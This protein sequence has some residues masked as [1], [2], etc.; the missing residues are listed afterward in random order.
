[1]Q[2]SSNADSVD[3]PCHVIR[4]R[5]RQDLKEIHDPSIN[6]ITLSVENNPEVV[7]FL[8]QIA[9]DYEEIFFPISVPYGCSVFGDLRN[10]SEYRDFLEEARVLRKI[11]GEVVGQKIKNGSLSITEHKGNWHVDSLLAPYSIQLYRNFFGGEFLW[12]PNDN[13]DPYVKHVRLID[14]RNTHQLEPNSLALFKGGHSGIPLIHKTPDVDGVRAYMS[15][16]YI[17]S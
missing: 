8:E 9:R 12:T 11:L 16:G 14:E 7:S 1:M 15:H 17:P 10:L 4:A 5:D 3:L 6:L 2:D 13:V